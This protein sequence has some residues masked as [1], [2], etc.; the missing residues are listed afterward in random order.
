MLG[1][2]LFVEL[3]QYKIGKMNIKQCKHRYNRP[4]SKGVLTAAAMTANPYLV[5]EQTRGNF[6]FD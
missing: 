6:N 3:F 1:T 4:H 5:T 2:V